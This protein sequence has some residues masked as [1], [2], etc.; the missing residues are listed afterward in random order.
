MNEKWHKPVIQHVESWRRELT[1]RTSRRDVIVGATSALGGAALS[2]IATKVFGNDEKDNPVADEVDDSIIEL[3][4][5][6]QLVAGIDISYPQ[7]TAEQYLNMRHDFVIVGVNG[8]RPGEVNP[9]LANQL[10]VASVITQDADPSQTGMLPIQLYLNTANPADYIGKPE[11][12][13]WPESDDPSIEYNP[14]MDGGSCDGTDSPACM[15]VYGWQQAKESVEVMFDSAAESAGVSGNPADYT[16]WLDVETYNSWRENPKVDENPQESNR[17][18][19][20]GM[21]A[22]LQ[23]RGAG[24][25][26]YSVSGHWNELI[27]DVIEED[28]NLF[29][30]P[31]WVAKGP[32]PEV[33]AINILLQGE[34]KPFTPGGKVAIIQRVEGESAEAAGALDYNY[35]IVPESYRYPSVG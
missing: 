17:I 25:G 4:R 16:W 23:S 6:P 31:S 33:D 12:R 34:E 27:G 28:S 18:V 26:I 13:Q 22:Y 19:L 20:E 15:Y 35:A 1:E 2:Q 9:Y 7:G 32:M 10:W 30:L 14:Y 21:V 24:V 3:E 5:P 29:S 8:G 11:L